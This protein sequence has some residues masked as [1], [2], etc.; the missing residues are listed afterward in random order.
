MMKDMMEQ[1][2]EKNNVDL[3]I[4]CFNIGRKLL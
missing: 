1:L 4:E 2:L 3:S